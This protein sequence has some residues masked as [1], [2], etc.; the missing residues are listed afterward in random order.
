MNQD[1]SA[2]TED[3]QHFLFPDGRPFNGMNPLLS[4]QPISV[5]FT[6]M[7]FIFER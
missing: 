6:K 1:D 4:S 7:L 3:V 5:Y 2:W